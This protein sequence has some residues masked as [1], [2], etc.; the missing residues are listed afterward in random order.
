MQ[1]NPTTNKFTLRQAT[2]AD[3]NALSAFFKSRINIYHH[4][5]W[6]S[7]L[8]WLGYQPYY[9][10]MRRGDILAAMASPIDPEGIS[11]IRVFG[12]SIELPPEK[13][14]P[15]LFD[16]CAKDLSIEP[17]PV[18][19]ALGLH[20]WFIKTLELNQFELY[21]HIVAL[22]WNY[23]Q[24]HA[25]P[26]PAG[27]QIRQMI[28]ADLPAVAQVDRQAFNPLWQNSLDALILAFHQASI[29]TVAVLDNK[30]VGYQIS[31]STP[32]NTHL[33]RLAVDPA[34]QRQNI[35]FELVRDMLTASVKINS[36]EIT[37]NT[38]FENKASLA[39]Y[40][41]LDF[42]KTAETFPVYVYR[43]PENK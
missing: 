2:A 8:E 19:A 31:T 14:F 15:I 42:T 16:Q 6:R 20:D 22:D 21:Q 3:L 40:E 39:L 37:V 38:Q 4:L 23:R 18:I 26:V 28:A 32:I 35:G 5:D 12:A 34:W 24:K 10:L 9:L 36:W 41:T 13:M 33:A 11:W 27:L 25:R 30:I 1:Q 43:R 17:K 29:A 7:S